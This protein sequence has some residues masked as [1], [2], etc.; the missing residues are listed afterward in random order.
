MPKQVLFP[1]QAVVGTS[2]P[3][4]TSLERVGQRMCLG[5]SV[6]LGCLHHMALVPPACSQIQIRAGLQLQ[7]QTS[8]R[9]G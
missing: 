7:P 3:K 4:K 5:G 6:T 8:Q 9:W 2:L 1:A